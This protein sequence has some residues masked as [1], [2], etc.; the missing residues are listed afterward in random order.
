M[1][2]K[3]IG[4]LK[5][6]GKQLQT[7]LGQKA[8]R[9]VADLIV[10]DNGIYGEP[11]IARRVHQRL[12]MLGYHAHSYKVCLLTEAQ[13]LRAERAYGPP[14]AA[15]AGVNMPVARLMAYAIK[16][17][18]QEPFR[19]ALRPLRRWQSRQLRPSAVSWAG[20]FQGLAYSFHASED[21]ELL[22]PEREQQ[23]REQAVRTLETYRSIRAENYG[24]GAIG[25]LISCFYPEAHIDGFLENLLSLE[26]PERLI[27]VI[28]NAGMSQE[29]ASKIKLS[30]SSGKFREYHI[31]DEP[32]C[33]IYA[34]WNHGL[35]ALGDSAEFITNFNVDD[36]RHPLCL[37]IQAECLNAFPDKDVAV[38]DYNYFFEPDY[39]IAGIYAGN[40]K[41]TTALPIINARTLVDRNLP[42]ASPLWRHSLHQSTACGL[43]DED[44]RSAG[45]ADFWYRVSRH[46]RN[47]FA[48][49]SIPLS[50]YY[51]NPKGLSTRP[52][53]SGVSEHNHC[54]QIHYQHLMNLIDTEANSNFLRQH[55]QTGTPENLQIY[56]LASS[57]DET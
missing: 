47:A 11:R 25:I 37:E 34:A 8:N 18:L 53:T 7:R 24:N 51:H 42:H 22:A 54:T 44:F 15:W 12:W 16:R 1:R 29:C 17:R 41:K 32:G 13:C 50:L 36:R 6:L 33:G 27:P 5:K 10:S 3:L 28:I 26:K 56:A 46:N 43:F 45:D 9:I 31:I 4:T 20:L 40:S 14:N 30:L 19:V 52:A 2:A 35:R 21:Q 48:V 55:L 38:T 39:D 49:I 23:I 57:F